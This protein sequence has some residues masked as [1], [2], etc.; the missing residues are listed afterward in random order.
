MTT[1][2]CHAAAL[3]DAVLDVARREDAPFTPRQL[4]HL[5]ACDHCRTSVERLR[6]LTATWSSL[7]PSPAEVSAARARFEARTRA[8]APARLVARVATAIA[9]LAAVGSAAAQLLARRSHPAPAPSVARALA[10]TTGLRSPAPPD[11][12]V[13]DRRPTPAPGPTLAPRAETHDRAPALSPQATPR[14]RPPPLA[15][16][17]TAPAGAPAD[18][19]TP[20]PAAAGE[21]ALPVGAD[22]SANLWTVAA[23][24]LR[25]GDH[26]RA[27]RAFARL[28]DAPDAYTRDAARLARAQ[29]W[30]SDGRT[31]SARA[32]LEALAA[33]GATAFIR[34]RAAAAL[35]APP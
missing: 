35:S 10:G 4:L 2:P 23:A 9:L 15:R 18:R 14:R 21:S 6:R 29:L 26:A 12:A 22:G 20:Q 3:A 8:R 30:I 24:A 5:Q 13:S 1:A 31:A 16:R 17:A 32:E 11:L 25:A 19:R 33:T 34:A 28:A 27:E 7:E